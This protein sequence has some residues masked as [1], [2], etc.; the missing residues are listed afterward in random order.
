MIVRHL[1]LTK[2][3]KLAGITRQTLR[4]WLE[5][6]GYVFPPTAR[7]SKLFVREC[8]VESVLRKRAARKAA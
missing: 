4:T 6:D 3:A 2:A 5:S 1:S 8:D 7:G